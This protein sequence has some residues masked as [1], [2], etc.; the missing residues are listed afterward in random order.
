MIAWMVD[1]ACRDASY[2][3]LWFG[4]DGSGR[5]AAIDM[6]E[7]KRVCRTECPV[8]DECLALA[9]ANNEEHGVWGGYTAE[10][11]WQLGMH[12]RRQYRYTAPCG[13]ET[14]YR[15]HLRNDEQPCDAC[16]TAV[17]ISVGD[18]KK[19]QRQ[20]RQEAAS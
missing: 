10:E 2:P 9:V 12:T 16:Q 3:D 13:T 17:R 18:R 11:R 1:A 15:R 8:V 14:A 6:A 19:R 7:A 5:S 20:A 4:M